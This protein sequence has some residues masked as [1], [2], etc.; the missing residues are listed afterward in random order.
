MLA[1]ISDATEFLR[2]NIEDP[3]V[4]YQIS[5]RLTLEKKRKWIRNFAE[6]SKND[7]RQ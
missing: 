5:I 2:D 4:R 3:I 7:K 6:I 1:I